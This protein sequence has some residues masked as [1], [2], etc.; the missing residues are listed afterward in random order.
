MCAKCQ[1]RGR[2]KRKLEVQ[3]QAASWKPVTWPVWLCYKAQRTAGYVIYKH[4]WH[5]GGPEV[6]GRLLSSYLTWLCHD[7]CY[8]IRTMG[9][10]SLGLKLERARTF[11]TL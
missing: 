1:L 5:G 2:Q 8:S 3:I 4:S 6:T 9:S 10:Q 7:G 11:F